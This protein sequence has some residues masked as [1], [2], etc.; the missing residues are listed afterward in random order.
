[1]T[2]YIVAGLVILG[3]LSTFFAYGKGFTAGEESATNTQ[4]RDTMLSIAV[5][6]KT[7]EVVAAAVKE[8][9]VENQTYVRNFRTVEKENVVYKECVHP[10]ATVRLL[11]AALRGDPVPTEP[12]VQG[13]LPK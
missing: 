1:M 4:L 12:A 9:K 6:D 11:N 7:L 13:E 10:D 5:R 3:S 8:I 2:A